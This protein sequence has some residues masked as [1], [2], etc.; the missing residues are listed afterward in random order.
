QNGKEAPLDALDEPNMGPATFRWS[1]DMSDLG[2]TAVADWFIR[3]QS[4]T[5]ATVLRKS[6]IRT[7]QI[8]P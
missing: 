1:V 6:E 4:K 3:L 8:L 5:T 2:D 7:F